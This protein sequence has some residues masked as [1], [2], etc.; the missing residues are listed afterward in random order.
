GS[1]HWAKFGSV[2]LTWWLGDVVGNLVVAPVLLTWSV[3]LRVKRL[4]GNI[5]EAAI[6]LGCLLLVSQVVF[7]GLFPSNF[8]SNTKNYPLEFVCIPFLLWA[9]FRFGQRETATA[10]LLLSVSA[11]WGTLR[12]FGPFVR[13]T[14]NES[15]LLLQAYMGVASVMSLM[16]AAVVSERQEV[17]EQ[18]RQ[19]SVSDPLTGI[20]NY[21]QLID[22]LQAEIGRS[23]RTA[24]SIAVLFVDL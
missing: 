24:R 4:H 23:Q 13:E 9:A 12:G 14:P 10:I 22:R 11:I 15:L 2:W 6:L 19:L 5:F 3:P 18:L 20:A 1:A 21:R 8:P 7:G 17:V 16:L